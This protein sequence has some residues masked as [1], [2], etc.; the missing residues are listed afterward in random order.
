MLT[1]VQSSPEL[2]DH[3]SF[4]EFLV[5]RGLSARTVTA[6]LSD[7]RKYGV[8]P[9]TPPVVHRQVALAIISEGSAPASRSRRLSALATFHDFTFPGAAN[10]YREVKRPRRGVVLPTRVADPQ[11]S[12]DLIGYARSLSTD[13]GYRTAA[14]VALMAGAGLRVGEVVSLRFGHLNTGSGSLRVVDGKGGKTRDVPVS[15]V[16]LEVVQEY[17]VNTFDGP[18]SPQDRLFSCTARTLA[19]NIATMQ[20]ALSGRALNPHA[21]RHGFATAVYGATTDLRVT[22]DLLGHSSVTTTM[23]YAHLTDSRRAEAVAAAL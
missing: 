19:R 16:V 9:S 5:G 7:L 21:F 17:A 2:S 8:G 4:Q 13:V 11:E 10:P 1:L 15:A 23:I 22:A 6:Y 3:D 18:P 14:A 20:E 12:R